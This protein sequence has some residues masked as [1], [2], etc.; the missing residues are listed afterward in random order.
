MHLV[1]FYSEDEFLLDTLAQY[2]GGTL[3]Q[4]GAGIVIATPEHRT[5]LMRRLLERGIPNSSL[6]GRCIFADA[7]E[8]LGRLMVDGM[9]NAARFASETHELLIRAQCVSTGPIAIYGEMVA[10]LWAQGQREAAIELERF[11]NEL[12]NR[13]SFTLR[14]GYPLRAFSRESEMDAVMQIC[15]EHTHVIPPEEYSGK[16]ES[17]LRGLLSL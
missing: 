13:E 15:S 2:I 3:A 12:G 10:L 1:Q 14:C 16:S 9:P 7:S 17:E 4:S 11:W 8:V 6:D 5:G